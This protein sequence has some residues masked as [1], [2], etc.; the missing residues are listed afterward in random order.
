MEVV[1]VND[2]GDAANLAYLL[3]HD[4][5]YGKWSHEIKSGRD[6]L[7]IDAKR[8]KFIQE[9]ELSKLPWRELGVDVV[10]ESTGFYTTYE[11]A[12]VH[13]D[14]GAKRVVITAPAHGEHNH[15]PEVSPPLGGETS[16]WLGATVLMGINEE[17]LK[18]CQISS[19]ASCT[20]N[21]SSPV[22][23]IMNESVGV[24]RAILSTTHAYTASQKIVDGPSSNDWREGRA[25]AANIIPSSTGAAIAV[26]KAMPEFAGK[27]DGIAMRVPVLAGS[28]A[29]ITFI[30]KRPTTVDEVNEIFRKAARQEHWQGILAVTDEPLVSSDVVGEMHA[31]IVDLSMTRVV[32]GNLV[33]V[34]SWY[35]N[36]MGY[37]ST[38]IKHVVEIGKY[39]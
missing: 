32:D 37:T 29:D 8:V 22:I 20:T 5:A 27:F 2:L 30:S 4:S 23:K 21:A 28:I 7:E 15:G 36:E 31:A 14:A 16:K 12:K 39:L 25:A 11:K 26:T 24:E 3:K 34:L 19:N 9:K 38:L 35:D 6:Y 18:I 10:I 17:R 13:I 1:A 33:K